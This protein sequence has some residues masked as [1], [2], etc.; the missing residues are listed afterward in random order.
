MRPQTKP[1]TRAGRRPRG[2]ITAERIGNALCEL[3]DEEE[4]RT[5]R[6]RTCGARQEDDGRCKTC[7]GRIFGY[8]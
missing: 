2:L 7:G 4:Q 1:D 8:E 3:P 5:F 6:C